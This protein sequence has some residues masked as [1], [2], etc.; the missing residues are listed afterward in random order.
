MAEPTRPPWL[1]SL[2]VAIAVLG[3]DQ[4]TKAWAVTRLPRGSIHVIWTLHLALA[5]NTGAA[6]SLLSGKGWG[7]A[8]ALVALI[9]V[10]GLALG[11]T[12]LRTPLAAA[13]VGLVMGGALGNLA[14]RAFRSHHG[15]LQG[16]VVDF[17]DFRWWPV[18]NLADA[19]ITVG[20]ILIAG[21][22]AFGGGVASPH[23]D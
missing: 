14:D 11:S 6:F 12:M 16:A 13:A 20:V 3:V 2:G 15:L 4:L 21:V 9:V 19:A 7:P 1:L 8:I 5:H 23:V 17:I 18:F 10:A 22:T